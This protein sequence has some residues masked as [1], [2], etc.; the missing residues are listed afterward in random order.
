M[1]IAAG[2]TEAIVASTGAPAESV[3]VLINEGSDDRYAAGGVMLRPAMQ[4]RAGQGPRNRR[5]APLSH[6]R[7]G[8]H[9]CV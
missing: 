6:G 5:S 3:H 8:A 1:W 2:V 7:V 9:S 4:Q